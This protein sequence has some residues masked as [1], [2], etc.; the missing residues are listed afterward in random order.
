MISAGAFTLWGAF[1]GLEPKFSASICGPLL[2]QEVGQWGSHTRP[3]SHR[4]SAAEFAHS[5][6]WED[7]FLAQHLLCAFIFCSP[8]HLPPAA[9]LC[10]PHQHHPPRLFSMCSPCVCALTAWQVCAGVPPHHSTSHKPPPAPPL[11]H[12]HLSSHSKTVMSVLMN[13]F[14][15]VS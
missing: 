1:I 12:T 9:T 6:P 3:I 13:S 10:T 7:F 11:S 5:D 8:P 14:R 4:L 15:V 2:R